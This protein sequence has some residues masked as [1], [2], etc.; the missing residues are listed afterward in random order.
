MLD[1]A[2]RDRAQR[3]RVQLGER[4]AAERRRLGLTQENLALRVGLTQ[5]SIAHYETGHLPPP[6]MFYLLARVL[7]VPP[8]ELIVDC[9][10]ALDPHWR[11]ALTALVSYQRAQLLPPAPGSADAAADTLGNAA[12]ARRS[13]NLDGA[14]RMIDQ[15]VLSL[16]RTLIFRPDDVDRAAVLWRAYDLHAQTMAEKFTPACFRIVLTDSS[17]ML[18]LGS[19]VLRHWPEARAGALYRRADALMLG[20]TGRQLTDAWIGARESRDLANDPVIRLQALRLQV[21]ISRRLGNLTPSVA[22]R[23][24]RDVESE[25]S[26][27]DLQTQ[28]FVKQGVGLNLLSVRGCRKDSLRLIEEAEEA[29][30]RCVANG[31]EDSHIWGLIQRTRAVRAALPGADFD[32]DAA[33]IYAEEGL[34]VAGPAGRKR[35][36]RH[37]QDVLRSVKRGLPIAVL[38]T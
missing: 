29:Y 19:R 23:M 11:G 25:S 24:L 27:V 32:P 33:Q 6:A 17:K 15:V 9:H 22:R 14:L 28:A 18:D 2:P 7:D 26:R 20:G 36:V 5:Q 4:L 37:C 21:A 31:Q 30:E 16:E 12:Q 8:F 3:G 38:P 34:D 10:G 35:T 1:H 13:G